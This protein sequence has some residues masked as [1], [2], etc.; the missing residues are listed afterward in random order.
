M[1][2]TLRALLFPTHG[3]LPP[4]SENFCGCAS[5]TVLTLRL[6]HS[7][8]VIRKCVVYGEDVLSGKSCILELVN[9]KV[10]LPLETG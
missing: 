7:V 6:K 9:R 4:T 3:Y 2:P 8:V 1:S 10:V 5:E